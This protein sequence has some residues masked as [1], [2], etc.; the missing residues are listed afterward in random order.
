MASLT[1]WECALAGAL[2]MLLAVAVPIAARPALLRDSADHR[3]AVRVLL[4]QRSRAILAH[5]RQAFLAT[6]D[7]QDAQLRRQ[8]LAFFDGTKDLPLSIWRYDLGHRGAVTLRFALAGFDAQPIAQEHTLSFV[9][10][11]TRW[12]VGSAGQPPR[13]RQLWDGGPVQVHRG[14]SCLVLAHPAGARLAKQVLGHCER[15]VPHV[16]GVWGTGWSQRVVVQV[17]DTAAELSALV[18]IAGDLTQI[19][20]VA[21]SELRTGSGTVPQSFA[22][23]VQVNPETF[24]TLSAAGR[25]VVIRHEITHVASRSV[26]GP[27]TPEWLVEGLADYVGYLGSGIPEAVSAQE[28]R[29]D[30]RDGRLPADLPSDEDFTG[31]RADL[32]QIYEQSWLAVS[33]V[34]RRFGQDALLRLYRLAGEQGEARAVHTALGIGTDELTAA[35]RDDLRR[36]FR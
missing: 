11:D 18:P 35:W 24:A 9:R 22:D 13:V 29:A 2:V 33:L 20:A 10:R 27:A 19:A 15:A 5:D 31:T 26:T 16:T 1:R 4:E 36:R 32:P 14:R 3:P 6:V 12:Y 7:P 21:T 30:V 25:E 8:Q 28:L 23:R 34:A 17:P